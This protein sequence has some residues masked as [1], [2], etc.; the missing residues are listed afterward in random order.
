MLL[1]QAARGASR[2]SGRSCYLCSHTTAAAA[3]L[4]GIHAD[5][6]LAEIKAAFR[7]RALA[8]HPDRGGSAA[9][10]LLLK[11]AFHTLSTGTGAQHTDATGASHARRCAA[12]EEEV[13]EEGR[14][15]GGDVF[16]EWLRKFE[17]E[18]DRR[19][20][21]REWEEE[22]E[23]ASHEEE[24]AAA[25]RAWST[26]ERVR[27]GLKVLCAYLAFRVS[28]VTLFRLMPTEAEV[29]ARPSAAERERRQRDGVGVF[30]P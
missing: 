3:A 8:A 1:A 30:D 21:A 20:R 27:F 12:A 5:A 11:A 29:K 4:L 2:R 6:P 26:H 22:S 24:G 23:R 10:F 15:G 9:D 28:L 16:D 18:W 13:A 7:S 14:D 25:S 17:R 19:Q